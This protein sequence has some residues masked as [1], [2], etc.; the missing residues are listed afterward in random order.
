MKIVLIRF[1]FFF[2]DIK[3]F[4]H[5]LWIVTSIH[6][7]TAMAVI[8]SMARFMAA[9]FTKQLLYIFP[10]HNVDI[11]HPLHIKQGISYTSSSSCLNLRIFSHVSMMPVML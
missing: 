10:P 11:L 2:L 1:F 5:E 7:D 9:Y 8:R 3:Y 6:T 4:Q